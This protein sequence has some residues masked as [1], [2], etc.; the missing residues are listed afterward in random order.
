MMR[1]FTNTISIH[2][3]FRLLDEVGAPIDRTESLALD[4]V[5]GR[6]LAADVVSTQ[7]VPS[8]DRAAMD[9]YAVRAHD[10]T[11]A[12]GD[13]PRTLRRTETVYAGHAPGHR[14]E[15]GKCA[16][17]ATGAPV[18]AGADAVVMI[19]E[20]DT[21]GSDVRV[22]A[23]VAPRQHIV[24]RASD[25][26]AGQ[27]VVRRGD[28][29]TPSRVG[30]LAALGATRV[31]VYDRPR[32]AILSTG[33]E[34][35]QPG[36]PLAPGQVYDINQYTLSA[37]IDEHGGVPIASPG[38]EDSLEAIEAGLGSA[39]GADVVVFSGGSSVGTRDLVVDIVS[40]RGSVIFHG[41]AVKPGKPTL[42]ATMGGRP[43]FGMPGN[44][45]S[46]LS[47]AYLLLVPVLRRLAHLPPHRGRLISAPLAERIRSTPGRHQFYTVRLVDGRA[48]P[49]FKGSGDITSMA[50]A[51]GYIEIPADLT[52]VE[53]GTMV[54][55]T[56]F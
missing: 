22:R 45:T 36:V 38:V 34:I 30:V 51:D 14:V 2:E 52:A 8:F 12:T 28:V 32:V 43:V 41:I 53:A 6:V 18:P 26:A 50:H 44:P 4:R 3:A 17:I 5:R 24:S 25:I 21:R 42:L 7:D 46:C 54:E 1:P 48:A 56:L 9:G 29:L 20:T 35:V 55:I 37:V 23:A 47:N 11:G 31:T 27:I 39:L 15:P 40:R 49:A 16:E 10:T 19:E 33:N 13:A